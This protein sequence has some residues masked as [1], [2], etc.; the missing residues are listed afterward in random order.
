MHS[1]RVPAASLGLTH[2]SVGVRENPLSILAVFGIEGNA[3]AQG[4]VEPMV[5]VTMRVRVK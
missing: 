3:D 4:D 1:A 5:A 2:R